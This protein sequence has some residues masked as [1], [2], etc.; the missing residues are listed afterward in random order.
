MKTK[1]RKLTHEEFIR[2]V[3][4]LAIS[5]LNAEE[6]KAARS[7]K[8]VYGAGSPSLRGVTYYDRWHEGNG[9]RAFVEIC[10]FGESSA[11]QVAGTTIHELG[12]VL[13]RSGHDR[14]WRAA[15]ARLGLTVRSAG[16][17][18]YAPEDFD[19]EL[20]KAIAALGEPADGKPSS[21]ALGPYGVPL[22][23]VPKGP[24]PCAAGRGARGGTS[25]G[26]G[27]GSRLLKYTCGC[28]IV[29]ASK[30]ADLRATCAK[31]G[32]EFTTEEETDR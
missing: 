18:D 11:T 25:R 15:C 7:V 22:G 29:R 21:A 19:P 26:A 16:G 1:K 8:L 14:T 4:D 20:W 10:A 17:Q 5:R 6:A 27:S 23:R 24:R 31:C 32:N 2:A 3:A 13:S 30:G 9:P 12:H 28:T